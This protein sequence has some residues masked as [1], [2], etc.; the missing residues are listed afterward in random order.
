[1]SALIVP[2]PRSLCPWKSIFTARPRTISSRT[3]VSRLRTPS[4]VAC[5]HVSDT[6]IRL[7]PAAIAVSYSFWSVSGSARVVSSVTNITGR[8]ALTSVATLVS[9][10]FSMAS[11]V[12]SSA[13]RRIGDEPINVQLSIA[14]PA[15]VDASIAARTSS[16][17]VRMAMLGRRRLS[18]VVSFAR[19]TIAARACGDA[20]GRPMSALSIP[21]ASMRWRRRF[22]MSS[23]GFRIEGPCRPSRSVSSSSSTAR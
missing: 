23:G 13:N 14:R 20:P 18:F 21:S 1:V 17:C 9:T 22:L 15:S 2:R 3:N 5:P 8:P 7:A 19:A 10:L 6:Q 12:Q 16:G 11:M 4:G